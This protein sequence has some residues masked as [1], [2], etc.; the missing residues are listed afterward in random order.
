M[1]LRL[2]N[3]DLTIRKYGVRSLTARLATVALYPSV[4]AANMPAATAVRFLFDVACQLV[5]SD[6]EQYGGARMQLQWH[7]CQ[8]MLK[9]DK[10]TRGVG[11]VAYTEGAMALLKAALTASRAKVQRKAERK[12]EYEAEMF[13][14]DTVS[15]AA[16]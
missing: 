6:P 13:N 7:D 14:A 8:K 10:V 11:I 9:N 16:V 5:K 12:A 3:V 1:Q 15:A 4:K 2:S